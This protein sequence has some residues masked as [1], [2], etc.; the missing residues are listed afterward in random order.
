MFLEFWKRTEAQLQYEWDTLGYEA[1]EERERPQFVQ[2]IKSKIKNYTEEQKKT[3]KIYNPV[4]E[5]FEYVQPTYSLLPKLSF[6]FSVSMTMVAGVVGVVFAVLIYRLAVSTYIYR[7]IRTLPGGP[8]AADL[9]TSV[10]GSIIQLMAIIVMNM[11]YE[12]VASRLTKW[13][14][15]Y[16]SNGQH[17]F[18]TFFCLFSLLQSF[19]VQILSMKTR[20]HSKCICSSSSTFTLLFFTSVFSKESTF[21]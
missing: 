2:A 21:L 7:L 1:A 19:T 4:L 3:Y 20:L 15:C 12:R 8:S 9:I 5:R 10:T 6:A 11:V 17:Y 13:G 18:L 16:K 14:K